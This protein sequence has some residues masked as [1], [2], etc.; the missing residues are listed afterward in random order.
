MKNEYFFYIH[1]DLRLELLFKR[2]IKLTFFYLKK[3]FF[4]H[5]FFL[6]QLI[7]K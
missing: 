4:K 5:I 6:N 2:N 3:K 7:D 1:Y